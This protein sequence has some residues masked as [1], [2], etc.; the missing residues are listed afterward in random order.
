MSEA[1]SAAFA[2]LFD[3]RLA[4]AAAVT[5]AAG[6]MRGFAGFGTAITLAPVFSLLWTPAVGVP[7]MLLMEALIG[8]QLLIGSWKH[9]N[10]R[11][12]FP[13]AFAACALV[14]AGAWILF[15]TDPVTLTRAMGVLVL[16]FGGLLAS[17]WRYRGARPLP[18]NI[19]VGAL[20]GVLKGSTGMSGPPVIL[21]LLAG[22][23]AAHEHRA[24]LILFFAVLGLVAL[25]PPLLA[26]LF[27]IEV[28]VRVAVLTPWLLLFVRIGAALFGRIGER[29]FRRVAYALLVVVGLAALLG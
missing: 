25:L 22:T 14:P 26:G 29:G 7:T 19:A 8:S 1:W 12:A 6:V 23:E 27:T 15:A 24:N 11:V 13:M 4:L 17:G 5:A 10:R 21:Y 28:L 9:V 2:A 16:L 3:G 20:A 18:L